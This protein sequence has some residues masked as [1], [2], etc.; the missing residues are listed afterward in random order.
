M[1]HNNYTISKLNACYLCCTYRNDEV[2]PASQPSSQHAAAWPAPWWLAAAIDSATQHRCSSSSR[3]F[4]PEAWSGNRS[5][6]SHPSAATNH[7]G[8]HWHAPGRGSI[9]WHWDIGETWSTTVATVV[10]EIPGALETMRRSRFVWSECTLCANQGGR[11][12]K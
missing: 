6:G 8:H 12:L 4:W 5:S 3:F 2:I 11:Y 9:A 7:S 1:V 10:S